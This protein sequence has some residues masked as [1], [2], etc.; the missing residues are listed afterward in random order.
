MPGDV[1][2]RQDDD[3]L[4]PDAVGQHLQRLLGRAHEVQ[5]IEALPDLAAEVL[6]EQLSNVGLIVDGQN[7]DGHLPL[8]AV[9]ACR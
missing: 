6:A 8:P 2:V 7:A 3:Q 4:R 1:Y 5:H 9:T